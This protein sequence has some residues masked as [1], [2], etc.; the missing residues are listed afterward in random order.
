VRVPSRDLLRPAGPAFRLRDPSLLPGDS[1]REPVV[2]ALSSPRREPREA[3]GLRLAFREDG[4]LVARTW[5][6]LFWK[7]L[8]PRGRGDWLFLGGVA[9]A[10]GYCAGRKEY[11]R[12]E[13]PESDLYED[14]GR[15]Y[16]YGVFGNGFY[17]LG[18]AGLFYATGLLGDFPRARRTGLL[19]GESVLA[20]GGTAVAFQFVFAEQRPWEGGDLELF[21]M[22]G[23]G[24][25][26]H[27]A[28]SVGMAR[29]L[30]HQYLR[31]R[32]EDGPGRRAGKVAGKVLL[33]AAPA[34]TGWQRLR[35]DDHYL[36]NVVLG[37]GIG[38]YTTGALLRAHDGAL[39][40]RL[41]RWRPELS[42]GAGPEG[43]DSVLLTWRF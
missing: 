17:V 37:A 23:H 11:L 40:E 19:L 25:S 34:L 28:I 32:A 15:A 43:V 8:A 5:G 35:K 9:V 24:A 18:A 36:W 10:S 6:G 26:G 33:Y 42:A 21:Q 38:W 22:G 12:S 3:G 13:V 39:G 1:E 7:E 16:D 27:A 14:T 30:D 2:L 4:H 41:P 31:F 29:V 20:A